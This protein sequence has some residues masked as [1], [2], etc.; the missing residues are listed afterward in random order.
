MIVVNNTKNRIP[1][2]INRSGV[3]YV[4]RNELAILP[5][6]PK[7]VIT[8]NPIGPQLQAPADAPTIVP[9]ILG[10]IFLVFLISLTLNTFIDTTTPARIDKIKINEKLKI[11]SVYSE[12]TMY[13]SRNRCSEIKDKG[14]NNPRV[15]NPEIKT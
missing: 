1:I 12:K 2:D 9:V 13:G 8:E 6:V 10:P 14:M 5:A 4:V 15:I 7:V 11:V 3:S